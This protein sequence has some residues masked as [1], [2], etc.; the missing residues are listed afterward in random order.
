MI[1]FAEGEKEGPDAKF[2]EFPIYEID[3]ES[4]VKE[5]TF[6]TNRLSKE[7]TNKKAINLRELV[8]QLLGIEA[9]CADYAIFSGSSVLEMGEGYYGRVDTPICALGWNDDDKR[10]AIIEQS[11]DNSRKAEKKWWHFWK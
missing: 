10:F 5:I 8:D 4:E 11:K 6:L 1:R 2:D 3:I 9:D 7:T